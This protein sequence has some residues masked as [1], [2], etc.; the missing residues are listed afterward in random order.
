MG[1]PSLWLG[2]GKVVSVTRMRPFGT[3]SREIPPVIGVHG[4]PSPPSG[5]GRKSHFC[6][7]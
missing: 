4:E 7:S 3:E 1:K 6:G 5:E 2:G